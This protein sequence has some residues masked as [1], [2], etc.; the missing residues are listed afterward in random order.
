MIQ[1]KPQVL[2]AIDVQV[3][4]TPYVMNIMITVPENLSPMNKYQCISFGICLHIDI[5]IY[6]FYTALN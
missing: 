5:S 6:L 3:L 1:E 4:V 2:N